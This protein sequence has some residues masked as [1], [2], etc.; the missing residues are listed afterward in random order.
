MLA[1]ERR[2]GKPLTSNDYVLET[3][4]ERLGWLKSCNPQTSIVE[5]RS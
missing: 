3:S 4:P 2:L 1:N 5:L